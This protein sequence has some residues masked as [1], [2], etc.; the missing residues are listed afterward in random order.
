MK[1]L[2][3]VIFFLLAFSSIASSRDVIKRKNVSVIN[4]YMVNEYAAIRDSVKVKG[5]AADKFDWSSIGVGIGMDFGGYGANYIAYL[6]KNVGIFAGGGWAVTKVGYNVGIK[7]RL[8]P[9]K[10]GSAVTPYALAMYGYNSRIVVSSSPLHNTIFYGFTVGVGAD[11]RL[12]GQTKR[13]WTLALFM[14]F[15]DSK[16]KAYQN[17]LTDQNLES[18]NRVGK[19]GI[20][21][22]YH[23]VIPSKL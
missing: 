6:H 22:G 17:Y 15:K 18:L 7:A 11:F 9:A 4:P 5:T 21:I 20:S 14:P 23:L 16:V 8:I 13:F 19:I 12:K 3:T 10:T 1:N 2:S